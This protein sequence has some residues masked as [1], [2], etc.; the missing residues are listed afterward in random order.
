V[1]DSVEVIANTLEHVTRFFIVY[2]K[3]VIDLINPYRLHRFIDFV[4][5]GCTNFECSLLLVTQIDYWR[6]SDE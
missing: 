4:P 3:L 1:D 2:I 5:N 6:A